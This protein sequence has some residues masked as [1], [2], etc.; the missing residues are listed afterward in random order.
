MKKLFRILFYFN[1][2]CF[3]IL[4]FSDILIDIDQLDRVFVILITIILLFMMSFYLYTFFF[5]LYD[6]F[7]NKGLS[8][9]FWFIIVL[10]IPFIGIYIYFEYN[11]F[12][13]Y[14]FKK[15]EK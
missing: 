7:T 13:S 8:G 1:I 3:Y 6:I 2:P 9:F 11:V 10:F 5:A 15:E 4:S 14:F 12:Y